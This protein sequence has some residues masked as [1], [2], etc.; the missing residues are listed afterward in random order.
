MCV[1]VCVF[2]CVYVCMYVCVPA[3]SCDKCVTENTNYSKLKS[4][5]GVGRFEFLIT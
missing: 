4:T 3:F 2:V 1:C 5:R